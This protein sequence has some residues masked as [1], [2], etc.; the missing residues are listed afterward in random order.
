[1]TVPP[2]FQNW[3]N[4]L[5]PH[6]GIPF[7]GVLFLTPL[8]TSPKAAFESEVVWRS[9]SRTLLGCLATGGMPTQHYITQ[10]FLYDVLRPTRSGQG[11]S[12]ALRLLLDVNVNRCGDERSEF[13]VVERSSE[14]RG[15]H[16]HRWTWTAHEW[17]DGTYFGVEM[18]SSA[19]TK[20]QNIGVAWCG[21]SLLHM[22]AHRRSKVKQK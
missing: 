14:A 18:C 17:I 8:R 11:M 7:F 16:G 21:R 4:M 13:S 10:A 1:M 2:T 15:F 19:G 3:S 20:S 9:M 12:R 6:R 22:H 5:Q